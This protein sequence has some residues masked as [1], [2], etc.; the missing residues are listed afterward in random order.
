MHSLACTLRG[1]TVGEGCFGRRGRG[2]PGSNKAKRR[3]GWVQ[4]RQQLAG[5]GCRATNETAALHFSRTKQRKTA[6]TLCQAGKIMAPKSADNRPV[7]QQLE[8]NKPGDIYTR[9]RQIRRDRRPKR[10]RYRRCADGRTNGIEMANASLLTQQHH[11]LWGYY[12]H[13]NMLQHALNTRSV[14]LFVGL[15]TNMFAISIGDRAN[16]REPSY[17]R[18]LFV[19]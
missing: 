16:T 9:D 10:E 8:A 17:V 14:P 1:R 6:S 18:L 4:N 13:P 5:A 11:I 7:F 2:I 3:R 12:M 15:Y 19:T